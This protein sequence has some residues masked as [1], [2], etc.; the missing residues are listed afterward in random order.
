MSIELANLP[1]GATLD[2]NGAGFSIFS[3]NATNVELCLFDGPRDARESQRVSLDR[4]GDGLWFTHISGVRAGQH[5]GYRIH[6]PYEPRAGHR[7]N[8]NKLLLDPYAKAISR[9]Q[10]WD[11][12]LLAY[13]VGDPELD[14]SIDNTD[15]AGVVPKSIVVADDLDWGN[16]RAP[17]TP[18]TS[19]FVYECHVKGLTALH[20]DIPPEIRGTYLG[21]ASAPIIEH[22]QSLGVTAVELLPVHQCITRR[23]LAVQGLVD[24]WGYNTIGFFAPDARFATNSNGAQVNEF[25]SMV[26][27]LH[28]AGIEVILD[29]VYNHSGEGDELGPTILFRGIDNSSYYRM[30]PHDSRRYQNFAGCGNCL[31][32][33]NPR[34]LQLVMDSLRYWVEQM[35]VD[36]FRFDLSTVLSRDESGR[37]TNQFYETISRDPVL[38]KVKLIAEPWDIGMDGYRVGTL[39]P[40]WSEWNDKYR[41]DIRRFWR[42]NDGQVGALASRLAG[43]EDLFGANSRRPSASINF[44]ACHDGF[45]LR[46]VVT[47][48]H[49]HNEANGEQ[50]RDGH[51]DNLSRNWGAEGKTDDPTVLATREQMQRNFL[52]TLACSLG[53]PMIQ[54]GDELGRTQQGNNNAYCHDDELTWV[55]WD[56]QRIQN[57]V[58]E[59]ARLVLN[60]RRR[61]AIAGR[62]G[63]FRGV[64]EAGGQL[65]DVTW[66]TE[67][68]RELTNDDWHDASRK[69][70]GMMVHR[71]SADVSFEMAVGT[72]SQT[73]LLILNSAEKV[74]SFKL[75]FVEQTGSWAEIANTARVVQ[76]S[77]VVYRD[78]VEMAACSGLLL[79]FR[80]ES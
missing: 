26:K 61:L 56:G 75:P 23:G 7:F 51:N 14:L 31:N 27:T 49:K 12:R 67:H 15:S 18:W 71:P 25:K 79:D 55:H 73:T 36:G 32:T 39:P 78:V 33:A 6:G 37:P 11:D 4:G 47:Y 52:L 60:L 69:T 16:D 76:T 70:L 34:V 41:D 5:Y 50:N 68:G 2:V 74:I 64:P 48:E 42:G 65:R 30:E 80:P 59:F 40:G 46:D 10:P 58:L 53:T 35:H 20:P 1:L 57:S 54:A 45:T 62:V 72:R 21:L 19:T 44:I 29:V 3:Q 24:Y 13:R 17:R 38:S 9:M 43:S 22:L 63:F 28:R 66:L 77:G 8:S